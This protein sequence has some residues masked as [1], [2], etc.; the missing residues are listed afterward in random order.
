MFLPDRPKAAWVAALRSGE[1]EQTQGQLKSGDAYCCLGVQCE[2]YGVEWGFGDTV[3]LVVRESAGYP[4]TLVSECF[5]TTEEENEKYSFSNDQG[6]S[7]EEIADFVAEAE[8]GSLG[9]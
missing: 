7:F 9:H 3:N 6:S 1:F 8:Y 4:P 2:L 5:E